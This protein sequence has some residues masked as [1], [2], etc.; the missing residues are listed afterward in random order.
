MRRGNG[1]VFP[2]LVHERRY[3]TTELLAIE[4]RVI[5]HAVDGVAAGRWAVSDVKVEEALACHPTLTEGQ[6]AMVR[7]FATSG[8]AIDIGVGAA[9]TGKTTVMAIIGELATDSDTPVVGAALAARTAAG[10]QAATGIPSSTLTRF[11]GEAKTTGG[12]ETVS[13]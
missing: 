11:L 7:Q 4:Q 13:S 8:N 6:R 2:G 9:G 10:F 1:D 12:L 3:T 5:D